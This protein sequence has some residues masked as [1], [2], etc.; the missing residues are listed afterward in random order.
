[1]EGGDFKQVMDTR[2]GE[3][4]LAQGVMWLLEASA[5]REWFLGL[6]SENSPHALPQDCLFVHPD[7]SQ[8]L[9]PVIDIILVLSDGSEASTR[10]FTHMKTWWVT[11]KFIFFFFCTCFFTFLKS[12]CTP[13]I[14]RKSYFNKMTMAKTMATWNY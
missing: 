13:C 12:T 6:L 3:A 11:M 9:S 14:T 10:G 7:L 1:M 2:S 5:G 8:V 4:L